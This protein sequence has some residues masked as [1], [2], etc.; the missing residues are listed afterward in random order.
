MPALGAVVQ[1][2]SMSLDRCLASLG[3]V[4]SEVSSS[5]WSNSI[6]F[7]KMKLGPIMLD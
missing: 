3:K 1:N 7:Q 4:I 2:G 5:I 6:K